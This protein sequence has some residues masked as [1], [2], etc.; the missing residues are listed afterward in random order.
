MIRSPHEALSTGFLVAIAL[1][2]SATPSRT[3]DTPEA[4]RVRIDIPPG[5][6]QVLEGD[7]FTRVA[8]EGGYLDRAPGEPAVPGPWQG[9]IRPG[10]RS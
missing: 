5:S 1:C 8:L 4:I 7:G 10:D 6:V 2:L 3:D 9:L